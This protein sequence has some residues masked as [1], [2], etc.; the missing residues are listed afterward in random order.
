VVWVVVTANWVAMLGV[1]VPCE[2]PTSVD[3]TVALAEKDG[4]GGEERQFADV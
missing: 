1:R 2:P 4:E 3:V